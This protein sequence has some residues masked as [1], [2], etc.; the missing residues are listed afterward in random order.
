MTSKSGPFNSILTMQQISKKRLRSKTILFR[1][2]RPTTPTNTHGL[3]YQDHK[4]V[5]INHVDHHSGSLHVAGNIR[6]M[7]G[8][9]EQPHQARPDDLH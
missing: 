8:N 1:S 3:Q 9:C 5:G 7:G 6:G 4:A 2:H